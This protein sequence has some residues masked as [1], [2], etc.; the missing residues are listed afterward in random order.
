M[1]TAN[2]RTERPGTK[3]SAGQKGKTFTCPNC[4]STKIVA[5]IE[6]GEEQL[7]PDCNINMEEK[8]TTKK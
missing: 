6:F 2:G 3:S 7:C 5:G 1:F 8:T 4:K